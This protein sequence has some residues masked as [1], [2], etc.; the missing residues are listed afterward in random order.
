MSVIA[1]NT[2]A[3]AGKTTYQACRRER[4]WKHPRVCGE[5][6]ELLKSIMLLVETPPRM[7]GRPGSRG[8]H[9]S[10][11]GNTPAYAGK[12]WQ[13]KELHKQ[14]WK[15]PR[16]CGEDRELLKSIMLLV[17]TPPRMRGRPDV[18]YNFPSR[19]RNTPAYAG[20]TGSMANTSTKLWKHPRVC[21]EDLAA[22]SAAVFVPET[23]PRMRGRLF[24][25]GC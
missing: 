22:A 23:P 11:Y 24:S 5:D 20:K 9:A 16:V 15:H 7:R 18:N 17:E 10:S 12:T 2:P 25:Y 8:T 14:R 6:R 4:R 21:G 3:Y 13:Y 19:Q 1:R